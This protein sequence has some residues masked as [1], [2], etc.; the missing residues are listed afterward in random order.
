MHSH[1]EQL[2]FKV[3]FTCTVIDAMHWPDIELPLMYVTG[4]PVMFDIPDSGVF[5]AEELPAKISRADFV[6]NNT[7]AVTR[8]TNRVRQS[9]TNATP[10]RMEAAR[11]CWKKTKSEIKKGYVFGPSS[12]AKLDRKYGRGKWRCLPRSAIFQKKKW[13]CIDNGKFSDHNKC[14]PRHER[15]VC[16]RA[17]FPATAAREFARRMPKIRAVCST[18]LRSGI[19]K[20][21]R[22]YRRW[23]MR[24]GT[25][26]LE[27]AYR[28]T[29]TSQPEYTT[30]A[31]FDT[32][33]D[34]VVY[35]ELP[36]HNFG[37]ASAVLNFNRGPALFTA[38]AR[39]LLWVCTEPYYDD[40]DVSE[41]DFCGSSGLDAL[42]AQ[43]AA[44]SSSGSLLTQNNTN[45]WTCPRCFSASSRRSHACTKASS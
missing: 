8:I 42:V 11:E 21:E 43:S 30:V 32:D 7:R 9:A 27:A 45:T 22:S 37:L 6:A 10:Q 34:E 3:A 25:V 14:Q 44:N 31:V 23:G 36:G 4:F 40:S 1:L 33:A 26:D 39:R 24:H 19:S 41:P 16:G 2:N 20:H 29:P 5:V 28:R 38:A 18:A 17:D 12:R 15:I 35:A 13:R